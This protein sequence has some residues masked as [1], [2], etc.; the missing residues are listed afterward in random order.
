M[1][2][3]FSIIDAI[4]KLSKKHCVDQSFLKISPGDDA[5]LLTSLKNPVIS[6]DTQ[7][8]NV[9]FKTEWQTPYDI[10]IKSVAVAL[11]DLAASFAAPRAL[12]INLGI[13]EY[14]TDSFIYDVYKGIFSGLTDYKC[15]LGGGNISSASEFSLD[16]F[17]IGEGDETVFP[18]RSQAKPGYGLYV[19]GSLGHARC[20]LDLLKR[21]CNDYPVLIK[22]FKYPKA[23]FDAAA[24]LKEHRVNCV[25]DLSDGLSGDAEHIA[26]ASDISI[27]FSIDDNFLSKDLKH[28]CNQFSLSILETAVAGGEEYEL[29]FA[30]NHETFQL[31][32]KKLPNAFKVGNCL[33]FHGKHIL[34]P[35]E[36]CTSYI[37]NK[38]V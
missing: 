5:A 32:N 19:T 4:I 25:M 31:I 28:F 16:I 2:D 14:I 21:N 18:L 36:T 8:E 23:R 9:H 24:I 3:E 10:G 22:A 20:G 26:E 7:R 6:T 11:S 30:C 15:A 13:P 34:N 38:G 37:H 1:S 35:P 27:E 17:A 33:P 12:F 29:L